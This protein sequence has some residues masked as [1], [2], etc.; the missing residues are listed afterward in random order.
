[1]D[2]IRAAR[3]RTHDD[4]DKEG[5]MTQELRDGQIYVAA[6]AVC[7]AKRRQSWLGW[8]YEDR[9]SGEGGGSGEGVCGLGGEDPTVRGDTSTGDPRHRREVPEIISYWTRHEGRC[10]RVSVCIS[11]RGG[12]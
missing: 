6:P 7:G 11:I 3:R 10:V 12:G 5:S 4:D 2:S 8:D 1:M 9:S